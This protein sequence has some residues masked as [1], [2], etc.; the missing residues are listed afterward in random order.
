MGAPRR[1]LVLMQPKSLL[2]LAPAASALR[3]LS[4]AGFQHVIDDPN[5]AA[6]RNDV[7][8]L[9]FCT[10]KVY[11]DLT[12]KPVGPDAA[13]IRVE[14]LYPWPNAQLSRVLDLYTQVKDI[15]WVQEEPKNMGA[16]A[17]VAPRLRASVGN[18]LGIRY[19]GRPERASPAEG[20]MQTHEQE[21]ARIVAEAL[22][23]PQRS[24][25]PRRTSGV[26]GT[27]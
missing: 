18:A 25:G 1:P 11:Y 13:V 5:G 21:Q 2:R 19:I 16:W 3:D 22:A 23:P 10:G 14:E 8:R 24:G 17:Y 20:F 7:K 26:L 4:D 15:V 6:K 12:A 27:V 9:V